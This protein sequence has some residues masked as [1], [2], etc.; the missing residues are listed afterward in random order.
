MEILWIAIAIALVIGL[1]KT[2]VKLLKF[3]FTVAL[4]AVIILVV[5]TF[6]GIL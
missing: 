1:I 2:T 5:T 6:L 4:I 3:I